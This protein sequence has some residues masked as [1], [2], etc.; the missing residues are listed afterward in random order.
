MS[1][2]DFVDTIV[3]RSIEKGTTSIKETV[4]PMSWAGAKFKK[5]QEEKIKKIKGLKIASGKGTT[6][7]EIG[8]MVRTSIPSLSGHY[9]STGKGTGLLKL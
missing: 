7:I 3:I 8:K 1:G 6:K 4:K 9:I 2:I 5:D